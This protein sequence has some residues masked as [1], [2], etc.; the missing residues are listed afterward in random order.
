MHLFI[1][2]QFPLKRIYHTI[3]ISRHFKDQLRRQ[4]VSAC[5]NVPSPVSP[6]GSRPIPIKIEHQTQNELNDAQKGKVNSL[7]VNG[8]QPSE[9]SFQNGHSNS[10]IAH[11]MQG[12]SLNISSGKSKLIH[13]SSSSSSSTYSVSSAT[14]AATMR[15]QTS[16]ST[17]TSSSSLAGGNGDSETPIGSNVAIKKT[18][19]YDVKAFQKEAVLSYVKVP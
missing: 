14:N 2:R 17:S 4:N 7:S 13:S 6:S 3:I 16:S 1:S 19:S 10:I 11:S 9:Q 18:S 8:L 15:M 5:R 12:K